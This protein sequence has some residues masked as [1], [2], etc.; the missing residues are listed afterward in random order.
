MPVI[1]PNVKNIRFIHSI[2]PPDH[3]VDDACVALYDLDD[4]GGYVLLDVV[5]YWDAEIPVRVHPHGRVH[6]LQ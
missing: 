2:F 6:G 3:L 1:L 5:G 4:L